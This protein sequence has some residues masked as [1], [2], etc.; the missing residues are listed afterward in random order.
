VVVFRVSG[1]QLEAAQGAAIELTPAGSRY[2]WIALV[3]SGAGLMRIEPA[4]GGSRTVK[5]G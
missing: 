2:E 1:P 5:I 4:G 3:D